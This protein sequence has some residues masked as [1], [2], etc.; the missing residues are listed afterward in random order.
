[1]CDMAIEHGQQIADN[2]RKLLLNCDL[3]IV[4]A[5]GEIKLANEEL[6]ALSKLA[7]TRAGKRKAIRAKARAET[8]K[9]FSKNVNKIKGEITLALD[10][11]LS[12]YTPK[13]KTIW[14]MYFIEQASID[15]I[16][17]A[18]AYSRAN[19]NV[20]LKKLRLDLNHYYKGS[21]K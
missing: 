17:S 6:K 11:V 16:C 12:R 9:I 5:E 14:W 13:Y 20:I 15:D 1:M 21:N 19:V 10:T 4:Y 2:I 7:D 8:Y 3:R 18:V